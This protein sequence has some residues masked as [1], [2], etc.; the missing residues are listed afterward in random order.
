MSII[1]LDHL[2]LTV[3]DLAATRRF[4]ADGLGMRWI[5]FTDDAGLERPAL[6]FGRQKINLHTPARSFEPK[7]ARPTPGSADIC[8]ISDAVLDSVVERMRGHGYEL[9]LGPVPRTGATGPIV[10]LY[11]RDPDG[12]LVEVGVPA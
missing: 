11:Y 7:A 3:S 1:G 6:G 2:V 8:L 12:N 4:Y 10:S 5:T 9:A